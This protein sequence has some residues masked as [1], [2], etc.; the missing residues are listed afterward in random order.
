[1]SENSDKR[2]ESFRKNV[3]AAGT[4]E[5]L[6]TGSLK[7]VRVEAVTIRACHTNTGLVYVGDNRVTSTTF[8]Y[9]LTPGETINIALNA[10]EWMKGA[11]INLIKLYI[12]VD[13]SGEGVCVIVG[14]D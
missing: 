1:M 13:T 6:W 2:I 8:S 9:A 10:E 3:T 7:T 14:G 5:P 12:D 4:R 11:S